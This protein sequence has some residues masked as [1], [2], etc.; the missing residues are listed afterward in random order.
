MSKSKQMD[1]SGSRVIPFCDPYAWEDPRYLFR[2]FWPDRKLDRSRGVCA[3]ELINYMIAVYLIAVILGI[4]V[5]AV[6]KVQNVPLFFGL[7]ATAILIP[8][9]M[10]LREVEGFRMQFVGSESVHTDSEDPDDLLDSVKKDSPIPPNAFTK[11]GFVE[12]MPPGGLNATGVAANP[13]SANP[14]NPFNNVL[15]NEIAWA[16]TRGEAPDITTTETK[17][18]LDDFFRVQWYSDPTDVFG[19][20]QSQRQFVSQP[21]TTIPNDQA[22]YQDWLYKIPGKTCKEGNPDACYGGTN[23]AQMPWLNG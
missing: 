13:G 3:S 15:I 17:I 6:A 14:A 22:S 2:S 12:A 21:S 11:E 1:S 8:T 9:F 7:I 19:R 18:A 4:V 16:P 23:G 20:S 5:G 10:K